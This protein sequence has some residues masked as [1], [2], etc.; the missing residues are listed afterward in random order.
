MFYGM[1]IYSGPV[2]GRLTRRFCRSCLWRDDDRLCL[3][4]DAVLI[5]PSVF[6]V[7]MQ[8]LRGE[9]AAIHDAV[10]TSG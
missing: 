8:I 6:H 10:N 2:S 9:H 3:Q 4:Q 7:F 5:E 1:T